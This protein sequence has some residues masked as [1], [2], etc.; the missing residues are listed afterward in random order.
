MTRILLAYPGGELT[1]HQ[2]RVEVPTHQAMRKAASMAT[3]LF[4]S[5]EWASD[6]DIAAIEPHGSPCLVL[7]VG[8]S[9]GR[10]CFL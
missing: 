5:W 2:Y 9:R 10:D 6:G 4:P 8:G 3:D 7:I 1:L